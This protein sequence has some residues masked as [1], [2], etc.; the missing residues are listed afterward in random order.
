MSEAHIKC[1]KE[2]ISEKIILVGNPDRAKRINNEFLKNSKLVNDYRALYVYTG[3][4]KDVRITVATTGMGSPSAAIVLEE[5]IKLGGK[6]FIRVGSAG[7]LNPEIK[8]GDIVVATASI[9]D[10][11][12]S[13]KYLPLEFP[14][15]PDFDLTKLLIKKAKENFERT[16]Y[17][18]ILS[19]DG[20]YENYDEYTMKKFVE[21]QVQAVEMESGIVFIVSQRRKVK[22]GAIFVID[23]NITLGKMKEKGKD[24]EFMQ[25]EYF[26]SKIAL[27]TISE[28]K[29]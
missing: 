21:S 17:G 1:E 15:V 10:D 22:A 4:Y 26:A 5:L 23:G 24:K 16:F 2:D 29:I 7:G 20:F 14:A 19:S 25:G 18:I 9:R 3:F 6:I 28:Y 13:L 11:G 8:T 12:T 27:E